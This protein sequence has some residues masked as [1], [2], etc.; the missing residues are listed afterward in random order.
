MSR[1]AAIVNPIPLLSQHYPALASEL[2]LQTPLQTSVTAGLSLSHC[3]LSKSEG[4]K[5]A[6]VFS[7]IEDLQIPSLALPFFH[8]HQ[9]AVD[10]GLSGRVQ[11]K[12]TDMSGFYCS[13]SLRW[14]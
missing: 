7:L 5:S 12:S 3:Y 14:P 6:G 11:A 8:W 4:A 1:A 13:F 2:A 10:V 9:C